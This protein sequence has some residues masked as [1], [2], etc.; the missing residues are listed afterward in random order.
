MDK[1]YLKPKLHVYAWTAVLLLFCLSDSLVLADP[2]IINGN[3]D[4]SGWQFEEKGIVSLTGDW[5]RQKNPTQSDLKTQGAQGAKAQFYTLDIHLP[6]DPKVLALKVHSR[7]VSFRLWIDDELLLH[8]G[9]DS[10]KVSGYSPLYPKQTAFFLNHGGTRQLKIQVLSHYK[11]EDRF[12]NEVFIGTP[13][14][15]KKLEGSE[16]VLQVFSFGAILI[17]A[18]YHFSL[19]LFRRTNQSTL[20]FGLL[21]FFIALRL[22]L[23]NSSLSDVFLFW[24]PQEYLFRV[25]YI[26]YFLTVYW[27]L[28][29]GY[30]TFP[31]IVYF[32][33]VQ[34]SRVVTYFAIGLTIFFSLTLIRKFLFVHEILSIGIG[35]Y[36]LYFFYQ[37]IKQREEGAFLFLAGF[38][39]IVI[40]FIND[41]LVVNHIIQGKELF[42][43]GLLFFIMIQSLFLSMR[44]SRAFTSVEKMS[45][46]L[47]EKNIALNDLDKLKDE[48]LA[49]TSHELRTPLNG[50]VGITDSLLKGVAGKLPKKAIE[51]LSLVVSSASR[52]SGLINDIL[53]YSKLENK[54]LQLKLKAVDL[55][56]I[57]DTVLTVSKQLTGSKKVRILNEIPKDIKCVLGDEN[58]LQQIFYNLVGNAI[59]FTNQGTISVSAVE[60]GDFI[61]ASV[62]DT[63]V[64]IPQDRFKLI[65]KSFEQYQHTKSRSSE[66]TG[67]GLSITRKLIELHEGKIWVTSELGKGSTFYFTLPI[68]DKPAD[69]LDVNEIKSVEPVEVSQQNVTTV[70]NIDEKQNQTKVFVVDD[71]PVN[72]QVVANFLALEN[73]PFE[74]LSSGKELIEKIEK[75]IVPDIV[76]LDIMMPEMTGYEVCRE[77]RKKHTSSQLPI[78]ML[79][80]KNRVSDLVEGFT[81]GANDYLTKPFS[82]DELIARVQSQITIKKAFQTLEQN[83]YLKEEL[84]KRKQNE[85]HLHMLQRKLTDI[86][87]SVPDPM[88]VIEEEG[89]ISFCNQSFQELTG[90][91]V[92]AVL[93]QSYRSFFVEDQ[94]L[95]EVNMDLFEDRI[96]PGSDKTYEKVRLTYSEANQNNSLVIKALDLDDENLFVLIIKESDP[97]EAK[98]AQ[99]LL[100]T[101]GSQIIDELNRN[102]SRI[103]SVEES[104]SRVTNKAIIDHPELADDLKIIDLTLNKISDSINHGEPAETLHQKVVRTMKLTVSYWIESTNSSKVDLAKACG[105]WKVNTDVN[106]WERARTLDKYLNIEKCPQRPRLT[107]VINTAYFVLANCKTHSIQREQLESALSE[108][109]PQLK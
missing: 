37:I 45:H 100:A 101:N 9:F 7:R 16:S 96:S 69:D 25:T 85:Q 95:E 49:N 44:F 15:F 51:N 26:G 89:S 109:T 40:V 5:K 54:D 57:A 76:L 43:W 80:A 64:G 29:F 24:L 79:T 75:G 55:R 42:N 34:I 77:L 28:A 35:L 74:L 81:L 105:F 87:D 8:H 48:F 98:L 97:P 39:V 88:M 53:D 30:H 92:Q 10:E 32:R 99:G 41:V 67:L 90:C 59:K 2:K 19:F 13:Q 61:E 21:C 46:E 84:K 12:K 31:K 33:L 1:F 66:G 23:H 71:E 65:F 82:R 106:G 72:L 93:G 83:I 3:I 70:Q 17:M 86:L 6:S 108:L 27:L 62:S 60:K 20:Y 107:H 18:I 52:L 58:R 4:L 103:R 73:I 102:R 47:Q 56:A 94:V 78:I 91:K 104:L 38:L 22:M 11:L 50:I 14:L 36:W 63:G 68:T